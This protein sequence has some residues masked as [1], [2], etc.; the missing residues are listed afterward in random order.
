ME[1][2]PQ[3]IVKQP[4]SYFAD[5]LQLRVARGHDDLDVYD[6]AAVQLDEKL[7]VELK[8]YHNSYPPGT[9]T[10]YFPFE[11][12]DIALI[13]NLLVYVSNQ[14][15]IESDWIAWQRADNPEL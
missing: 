9:T 15:G 1:F 4:L 2:V 13:T 12:R 8:H 7:I 3:A 11:I 5:K 6:A 10:I 14:L